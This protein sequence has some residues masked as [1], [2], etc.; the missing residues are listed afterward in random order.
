[1]EVSVVIPT[2]NR[3]SLVSRCLIGVLGQT[4]EKLEAIIVDDAS[5]DDTESE[6]RA[7]SDARVRYI[8]H[9]ENLG[10]SASRN[11]GIR[12]A[13]HEFIAFLDSDDEWVPEKLERQLAEFSLNPTLGFVYGG[14]A[15]IRSDH[16]VRI[17][18]VPDR[19]TG[20]IDGNPRWF[21]NMVQDVVVRRELASDCLFNETIWAYENLEWLL[22][23]VNL[24]SSGFVSEIVVRCNEHSA[25]RASDSQLKKLEGL[26][27]VLDNYEPYLRNYTNALF[28]LRLRAGALG[29]AQHSARVKE[30]LCAALRLRPLSA[31]AWIRLLAASS[32][33][34]ASILS[35]SE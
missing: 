13:K 17:S 6:V 3:A 2:F 5:T 14:W 15:W 32:G 7:V 29:L 23:L 28:H 33:S 30:H 25:Y 10:P 31:R 18:R 19:E 9:D 20:L 12:N 35:S 16:S 1:M 26:E 27:F 24:G 34:V 8:R 22:R 4:H 21:F 11:T